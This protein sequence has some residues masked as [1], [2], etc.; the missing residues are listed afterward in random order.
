MSEVEEVLGGIYEAVNTGNLVLLDKY[1]APTMS[2]TP[3]ASRASSRSGSRS[4]RSGPPF[5]TCT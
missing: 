3:R 5:P 1:V 4:A 2:S